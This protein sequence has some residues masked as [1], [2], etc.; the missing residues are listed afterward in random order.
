MPLSNRHD[1][2]AQQRQ[3]V[4]PP[5]TLRYRA[6]ISY[7]QRDKSKA[8]R[9]HNALEAYRIPEALKI[10]GSSG[11]DRRIGRFFRDD[12]ELG[13]ASD[14]GAALRGAIEDSE[15]LIVV[16]SPHAA[17]SPWVNKEV[18][19]FK[20]TE[21]AHRIFAVI[22]GGVPSSADPNLECFPPALRFE[23]DADGSL[24]DRPT[25][26]MAI[27]LRTEQFHRA[28]MRLV[29]GLLDAPFDSLWRRERRRRRRRHALATLSV[30]AAVT[31]VLTS[32]QFYQV[33][34]E[35]L[36]TTELARKLSQ[37]APVEADRL[38][39]DE[40]A[41]LLAR[42]AYLFDQRADQQAEAEIDT[43]LRRVVDRPYFSVTLRERPRDQ[44]HALTLDAA[45]RI[46]FTTQRSGKGGLI[47]AVFVRDPGTEASAHQIYVHPKPLWSIVSARGGKVLFSA[48]TDG[49]LL[50]HELR[51]SETW[52]TE[53]IAR[54]ANKISQ[55]DVS[56]SGDLIAWVGIVGATSGAD[57]HG[58]IGLWRHSEPGVLA[59]TVVPLAKVAASVALSPDGTYLAVGDNAGQFWLSNTASF[60]VE[61]PREFA[62]PGAQSP[63]ASPGPQVSAIRF[64]PNGKLF[65]TGD[66]RGRIFLWS[67]DRLDTG[68]PP[69]AVFGHRQNVLDLEFSPDGEF[70]ASSSTEGWINVW[71]VDTPFEPI[72]R[73][74]GHSAWAADIA[75]SKDGR[76]LF[77]GGTDG[78]LKQWIRD[79]IDVGSALIEQREGLIWDVAFIDEETIMSSGRPRGISI[80]SLS[81]LEHRRRRDLAVNYSQISGVGWLKSRNL[82]AFQAHR[83]IVLVPTSEERTPET[84]RSFSLETGFFTS[85][86]YSERLDMLAGGTSQGEILVWRPD[87]FPEPLLR[88]AASK[89]NSPVQGLAFSPNASQ[90]VISGL[91]TIQVWD[92]SDLEPTQTFD[93]NPSIGVIGSAIFSHEGDRVIAG[94]VD[95]IIRIYAHRASVSKPVTIPAFEDF[96]MDFAVSPD[97]RLLAAAGGDQRVKIWDLND[98]RRPP[99]VLVGH[100]DRVTSVGFSPSGEKLVSGSDDG[101]IRVWPV[102][103]RSLADHIC[104]VVRRN[105]TQSEWS[106]F[107][108]DERPYECTCPSLPSASNALSCVTQ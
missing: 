36:Q 57:V 95:G 74:R 47:G 64:H 19:H 5:A 76:L 55:I 1:G 92:I 101:T 26:P 3:G 63:P 79:P 96:V 73:V 29:A 13:A 34:T 7:S 28:L 22:V 33:T 24:A 25:E 51:G 69:T 42:Q 10:F 2:S 4:G 60:G 77:S 105:L 37:I 72:A 83:D 103:T 43:T 46:A 67:L 65:A 75:F 41:A 49:A 68:E 84:T 40:R 32:I 11:K 48:A 104:Q 12:D 6:F 78:V 90:L 71:R 14:L 81:K 15:C 98:T 20:T 50:R 91:N 35:R 108:G 54:P 94:G 30:A 88:W 86:G 53:E 16:C 102:Q 70:L 56:A 100:R 85:L 18:V 39:Q 21:R 59:H 44:I 52:A 87:E 8:R 27:D 23:V 38:S 66:S 97:G 99:K 17:K 106:D 61:P 31:V 80:W 93:T 9:L 62:H 45:S 107:V 82:V 89:S 58:D